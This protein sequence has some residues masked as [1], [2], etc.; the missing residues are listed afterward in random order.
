MKLNCNFLSHRK[1]SNKLTFQTG[2]FGYADLL[3]AGKTLQNMKLKSLNPPFFP[4]RFPTALLMFQRVL[5][6]TPLMLTFLQVLH[7]PGGSALRSDE[8]T[9][10]CLL[11][12]PPSITGRSSLIS[13]LISSRQNKKWLLFVG[14]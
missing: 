14:Y 6:Q 1:S 10:Y 3:I 7:A 4:G 5:P 9:P 13:S 11:E 12:V 8:R 2:L